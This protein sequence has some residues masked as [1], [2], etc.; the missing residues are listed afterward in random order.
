MKKCHDHLGNE[1]PSKSALCRHYN[2]SI[3]LLTNRLDQGWSLEKAL[4]T[5][6]NPVGNIGSICKDHLGNQFN[7]IK[8]MC[9]HYGVSYICFYNR[10]KRGYG[11]KTALTAPKQ[12]GCRKTYTPYKIRSTYNALQKLFVRFDN[13]R[14]D[15]LKKL[16]GNDLASVYADCIN[17]PD[18]FLKYIKQ[19]EQDKNH[20]SYEQVWKEEENFLN[21]LKNKEA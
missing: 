12:R 18:D 4:T 2:I 1:F 15:I 6:I 14:F 10:M 19:I 17:C 20:A 9:A 5:P 11:L 16:L 21:E 7:T 8:E 13:K 3:V